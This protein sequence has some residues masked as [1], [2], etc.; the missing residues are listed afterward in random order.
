MDTLESQRIKLEQETL[1]MVEDKQK[2]K[3]EIQEYKELYQKTLREKKQ[4]EKVVQ[5]NANHQ[6]MYSL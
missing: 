5:Y 1:Q 2:L 4:L 3:K 6:V